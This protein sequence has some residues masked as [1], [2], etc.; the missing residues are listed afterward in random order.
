M[1][2]YANMRIMRISYEKLAKFTYS[3]PSRSKTY[4]LLSDFEKTIP[5]PM[6]FDNSS[7]KASYNKFK[8]YLCWNSQI[9]ISKA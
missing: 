9:R 3:R 8:F 5:R 4:G 6:I 7:S 2:N 1:A